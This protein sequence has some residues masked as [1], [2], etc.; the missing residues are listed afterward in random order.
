MFV[1]LRK[2][3]STSIEPDR[4]SFEPLTSGSGQ[5][6]GYVLGYFHFKGHSYGSMTA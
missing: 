1:S 5:G 2:T 4:A 6:S 3:Q